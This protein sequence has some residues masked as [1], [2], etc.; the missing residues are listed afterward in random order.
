MPARAEGIPRALMKGVQ[1][2]GYNIDTD[3]WIRMLNDNDRWIKSVNLRENVLK[4][5]Y[6]W[7]FKTGIKGVRN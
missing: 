4:M 7:H 3:D 1:N 5:F 2:F 6:R